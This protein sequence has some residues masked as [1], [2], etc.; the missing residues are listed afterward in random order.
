MTAAD[1][2]AD[3][4]PENGAL[5]G[6]GDQSPWH[7]GRIT[8]LRG[9]EAATIGS[10]FWLV[11]GAFVLVVFAAALVV[12]FI[13]VTSDN[14]RIERMKSHGI[15]VTVTVV[16]CNGNIGVSGSN[17]AGYTC[18]GDYSVGGTTYHELICSMTTFS[19][20]GSAMRAVVD[21]S[22]HST[23][24]LASSLKASAASSGVY[25]A[26]GVLTFVL[27][28]LTLA[29]LRVARRSAVVRR[30]TSTAAQPEAH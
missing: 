27:V 30:T 9:A 8:S 29:L 25:V 6:S 4:P 28:A 3:R 16:D 18:R 24:A 21:P 17:A 15:P 7:E 13:A 11:V 26:P 22:R 19:A 20:V 5:A 2:D 10:R 23:V 1:H 14:A 12:G